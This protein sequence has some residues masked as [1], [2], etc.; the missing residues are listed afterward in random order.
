MKCFTHIKQILI[1]RPNST[2]GK[3]IIQAERPNIHQKLFGQI[4]IS[5]IIEITAIIPYDLVL[6]LVFLLGFASTC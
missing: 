2:R 6:T 1:D 5:I 3:S 4:H